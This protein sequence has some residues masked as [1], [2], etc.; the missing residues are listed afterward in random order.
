MHAHRCLKTYS[1]AAPADYMSTSMELTFVPNNT[2]N[3]AAV[4]IVEDDIPELTENFFATLTTAD[5]ATTLAPDR[6][7]VN[8]C[9]NIEA[10]ETT[11]IVPIAVPT[12]VGVS[13]LI[14]IA[15]VILILFACRKQE[16]DVPKNEEQFEIAENDAY[17]AVVAT[18]RNEAY[19][20]NT[21]SIP[22]VQNK[23][24]GVTQSVDGNTL[25]REDTTGGGYYVVNQP[26]YAEL[27]DQHTQ[28]EDNIEHSYEYV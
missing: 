9:N 4:V 19:M 16:T 15:A 14:G 22:A 12:A 23:A 24:Y 5:S 6:A 26:I 18:E 2:R 1:P 17:T 10:N 20:T 13:L 8:I 27:S 11:S 21:D 25:N 7:Q 28:H 3:C